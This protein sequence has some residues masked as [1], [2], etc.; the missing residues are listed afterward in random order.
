MGESVVIHENVKLPNS[1]KIES[2]EIIIETPSSFELYRI[3]ARH[4][5]DKEY[6][7]VL[8]FSL[9]T[10]FDKISNNR[11]FLFSEP[12]LLLQPKMTRKTYQN[13]IY[14]F[15]FVKLDHSYRIYLILS[16]CRISPEFNKYLRESIDAEMKVLTQNCAKKIDKVRPKTLPKIV[17]LYLIHY[18][19]LERYCNQSNILLL[20]KLN[21]PFF[22]VCVLSL[23]F[24]QICERG[25][26]T[27]K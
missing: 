22:F 1:A 15:D 2:K 16:L 21:L 19:G 18:H 10:K 3:C 14:L 5:T 20:P 4:V 12:K 17:S 8:E 23:K 11:K 25:S 7:I 13:S 24:Q 6:G 9:S 26:R 27:P